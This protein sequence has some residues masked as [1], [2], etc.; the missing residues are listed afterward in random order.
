MC[1]VSTQKKKPSKLQNMS[2]KSITMPGFYCEDLFPIPKKVAETLN[3]IQTVKEVNMDIGNNSV[4][5]LGL[6]WNI[7]S[8]AL[9]CKVHMDRID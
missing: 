5:T 7:E 1:L 8:D 3:S 4:K 2:S 6:Y 9:T